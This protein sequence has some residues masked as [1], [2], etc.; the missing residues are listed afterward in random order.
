MGD[1]GMY[2]FFKVND[3]K[4]LDNNPVIFFDSDGYS[5]VVAANFCEL[6]TLLSIDAEP[7]VGSDEDENTSFYRDDEDEHSEEYETFIKWLKERNIPIIQT[8]EEIEII[9]D[10]IIACAVEKYNADLQE[11]LNSLY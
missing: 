4:I 11:V 7:M 5:N 6:L 2:A 3:N 1:G 8:T 10:I 9:G